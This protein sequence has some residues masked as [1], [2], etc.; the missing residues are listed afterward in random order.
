MPHRV[1]QIK[2]TLD[3]DIVAAFKANCMAG[4]VS[5]TSVIRQ[6]MC[7]RPLT[8]DVEHKPL[9]RP[10]R[11]IAVMKIIAHL[12]EILTMEEQYRDSIPEQFTQRFE[13]SEHACDHLEDAIDNLRDAFAP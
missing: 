10:K 5:M 12:D 11:R 2:F 8:K 7:T 3:S 13:W 6:W 9:T 1:T 4:G